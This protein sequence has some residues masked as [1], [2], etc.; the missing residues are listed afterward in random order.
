MKIIIGQE[1]KELVHQG[2]KELYEAV[3]VTLGPKG[4]N[5]IVAKR[6]MSPFLTHDGVTVAK[7]ATFTGPKEVGA[8]FIRDAAI[9]NAGDVG[10]GTTSTTILTY[11]LLDACRESLTNPMILS[12][13]IQEE[14]DNLVS[15][16]KPLPNTDLKAI[17]TL[18]SASE[19]IGE[20]V[21]KAVETV[22]DGSVSFQP[23]P[24]ETEVEFIEGFK[25]N[26]GFVS[27]YMANDATGSAIHEDMPTLLIDGPL[28]DPEQL[29]QVLEYINSKSKKLFII[30]DEINRDIVARF[31][32]LQKKGIDVLAVTAPELGQRRIEVI[33]DIQSI[34]GGKI[35]KRPSVADLGVAK[36]IISNSD[37]TV[38]VGEPPLERIKE[39]EKILFSAP[40]DRS[41]EFI[42]SRISGLKGKVAIIHV[43][44]N[45]DQEIKEKIF[46][47]EDA[48]AATKAA[49]LEGSVVGGGLSY[50]S[51]KTS[52]TEV[53]DIFKKA[54]EQPFRQLM[55]N[56]GLDEEMINQ[57]KGNEGI[58]V[59]SPDEPVDLVSKNIVDPLSVVKA[60]IKT[61][62]ALASQL[63]T[64]GGL[65]I[66]E[67]HDDNA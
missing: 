37:D 2:A 21:S 32:L 52:E 18:S 41:A 35:T 40:N 55:I 11:S 48:V 27:P 13:Q 61:S 62:A 64:M 4:R 16:L 51:L 60:A 6:Y 49:A 25:I 3:R 44:G 67:E 22:G 28:N 50:L 42:K 45:S 58:D 8:S 39:L 5:F 23:S 24:T 15:Q 59:L 19:E 54:L 47:V 12:K 30:A 43:G 46:R 20:V 17:A 14:A 57:V 36:K 33:K 29:T 34:V 10:D 63:I 53:G 65:E 31:V 56:A 26:K 38:F 9:K 1:A 7:N 66:E